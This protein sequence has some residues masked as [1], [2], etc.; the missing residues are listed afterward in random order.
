MRAGR[1]LGVSSP[2]VPFEAPPAVPARGAQSSF[3]AT[4]LGVTFNL[5][6]YSGAARSWPAEPIVFLSW[7]RHVWHGL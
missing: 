7:S 3:V 6:W 4:A 1:L 2:F 5:G